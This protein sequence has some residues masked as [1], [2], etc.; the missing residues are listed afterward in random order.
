LF[1]YTL[2]NPYRFRVT[3]YRFRVTHYRFRV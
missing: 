2:P 1:L 3:H